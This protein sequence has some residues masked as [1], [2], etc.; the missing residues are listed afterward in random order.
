MAERWMV[1][2]NWWMNRWRIVIFFLLKNCSYFQFK[3]DGRIAAKLILFFFCALKLM[4]AENPDRLSEFL[5]RICFVFF[6]SS[7]KK[8]SGGGGEMTRVRGR[9]ELRGWKGQCAGSKINDGKLRSTKWHIHREAKPSSPL[10]RTSLRLASIQCK[11]TK[12]AFASHLSHHSN[13]IPIR[14]HTTKAICISVN[15]GRVQKAFSKT[16]VKTQPKNMKTTSHQRHTHTPTIDWL[17]S[18]MLENS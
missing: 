13:E 16:E 7:R 15:N 1:N 5:Q 6:S 9:V 12:L 8:W 14:V 18:R 11:T 4:N 17:P 10:R 3:R 2:W